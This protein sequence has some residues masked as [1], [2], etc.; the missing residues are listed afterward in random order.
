MSDYEPT[1]E[2]NIA[3]AHDSI[4]QSD[5]FILFTMVKKNSDETTGQIFS[6]INSQFDGECLVERIEYYLEYVKGD[7]D[8]ED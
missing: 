2:E 6:V 7:E 4:N 8:E 5:S 1:Y 3:M